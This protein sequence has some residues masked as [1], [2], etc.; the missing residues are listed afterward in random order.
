VA[1]IFGA[2]PF[3]RTHWRSARALPRG[4]PAINLPRGSFGASV[5]DALSK[6]MDHLSSTQELYLHFFFLIILDSSLL[7]NYLDANS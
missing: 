1:K 4:K 7:F 2:A 3:S 6:S 5:G